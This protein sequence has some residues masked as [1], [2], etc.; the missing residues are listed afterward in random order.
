M[1]VSNLIII[2]IA[3]IYLIIWVYTL[4]D[5]YVV[6]MVIFILFIAV[7]NYIFSN[8][9]INCNACFLCSLPIKMSYTIFSP[10]VHTLCHCIYVYSIVTA[11][12]Q[13]EGEWPALTHLTQLITQLKNRSTIQSA[14]SVTNLPVKYKEASVLSVF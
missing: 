14:D 11:K 10:E 4:K 3:Y 12:F 8:I 13:G 9:Y 2:L 7:S 5:V 6:L 1:I